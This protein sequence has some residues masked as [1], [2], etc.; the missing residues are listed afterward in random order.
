MYIDSALLDL[1]IASPLITIEYSGTHN[2]DPKA[3]LWGRRAYWRVY[4]QGSGFAM[5]I[6]APVKSINPS[7]KTLAKLFKAELN[8]RFNEIHERFTT[9][10]YGRMQVEYRDPNNIRQ[11]LKVAEGYYFDLYSKQVKSQVERGA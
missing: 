6:T 1:I 11:L 5:K 8:K 10:H 2:S 9:D 4:I 7:K 3:P